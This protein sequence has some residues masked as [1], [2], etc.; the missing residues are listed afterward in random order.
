MPTAIRVAALTGA[1]LIAIAAGSIFLGAS[2]PSVAPAPTAGA[3]SVPRPTASVTTVP[4]PSASA[5]ALAGPGPLAPGVYTTSVQRG[6]VTLA[7]PSGWSLQRV[8]PDDFALHLDAGPAD[9]TVRCSSTCAERRRT[10]PAQR[11]RSE[12]WVS[13]RRSSVTPSPPTIIWV[14]AKTP[15]SV[16]GLHGQILD[17]VLAA[18]TTR[19]CPFSDGKPSVPLIVDAID[20]TGPLGVGPGEEIRLVILDTADHR[21]IVIVMDA[22]ETASFNDLVAAAMPI[23]ESLSF[24][25]S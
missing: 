16:N 22:A 21:N 2:R 8:T 10:P 18:G 25:P 24:M 5:A 11:L 9:D 23:V 17:V 7:L 20:G 1:L 15:I 13:R 4:T 19:T 6:R 3:T 14:S 12:A